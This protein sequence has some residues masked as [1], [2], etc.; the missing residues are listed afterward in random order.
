[1]A[2]ID[3]ADDFASVKAEDASKTGPEKPALLVYSNCQGDY[4]AKLLSRIEAVRQHVSIKYLF[5]H[6]LEEPGQGWDTYPADYLSDVSYVWEQ[7]SDAF[8]TVRA[9][10]HRRLPAGARLVRFPAFTAGMIWPF[11]GPDPRPSN[12][13]LYMYGDS[14]A[15]RIGMQFARTRVTDDDIFAAYMD[16]SSKKMPDLDRRLELETWA[17]QKRDLESDIVLTDYLLNNFQDLQLFY[18][19]ARITHHLLRY[20]T[21]A[22]ISET[23]DSRCSNHADIMAAATYLLRDHQ[24]Y[25]TI[26]LP[27]H[28]LVAER[29]KLRWYDPDATYRWFMHDWTFRDWVV[30]C[31]R[32]APYVATLF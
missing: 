26:S 18:E 27:V 4:I 12:R 19:P 15:A 6:S 31:A 17:W 21:L 25:D 2:L 7:V 24:G 1:M 23:F 22:L 29:L 14:V 13:R 16:L 9:E 32:L 11:A 8:P 10:L 28:P 3:A 20:T 30:R 5:I